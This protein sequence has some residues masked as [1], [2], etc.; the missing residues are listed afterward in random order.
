VDLDSILCLVCN[1][2]GGN[3]I[4]LY[5]FN[6]QDGGSCDWL[7]HPTNYLHTGVNRHTAGVVPL[8]NVIKVLI[9]GDSHL[10]ESAIKINQCLN[11]NFVVSSFIRPGASIRQI[12]HSQG[13]E[14]KC[15]GK[16]DISVINGWTNDLDN[17]S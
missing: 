10:K 12:V 1:F 5:L 3:I 17:N 9:I 14:F 13:M 2:W 7:F 16:K 11:T 8:S 4:Q 15:L 6:H